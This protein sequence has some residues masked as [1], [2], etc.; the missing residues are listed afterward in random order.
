MSLQDRAVEL[1]WL[2]G[3][4]IDWDDARIHMLSHVVNY[5]TGVFE[6]SRCYETAS[7]G[8]IF[9]LDSHLD[10][11]F[12]SARVMGIELEYSK[13]EL[14]ETTKE[15]RSVSRPGGGSTPRSFRHR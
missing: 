14:A 2:N 10:R 8:A 13:D 6:G 3:Q 5:G 11:F 7:G 9:R 1:V 12:D 4:F 15:P